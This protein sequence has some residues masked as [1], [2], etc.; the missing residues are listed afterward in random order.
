V[1]LGLDADVFEEAGVPEPPVAVD[2]ELSIEWIFGL[3]S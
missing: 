1:I 3:Q 2:D